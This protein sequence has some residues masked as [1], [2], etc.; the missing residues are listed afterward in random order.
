MNS[1]TAQLP[2]SCMQPHVYAGADT[3][4][5][6]NPYYDGGRWGRRQ[7]LIKNTKL[8][9]TSLVHSLL[10][11][12]LGIMEKLQQIRERSR[13]WAKTTD[14]LS[15]SLSVSPSLSFSVCLSVHICLCVRP[16]V[17]PCV[18]QDY[19]NCLSAGVVREVGD[20]ASKAQTKELI[21]AAEA[22][23]KKAHN[24]HTMECT[25]PPPATPRAS[26]RVP[27]VGCFRRRR[28]RPHGVKC[29]IKIKEHSNNAA[30]CYRCKK[31]QAKGDKK[32][33]RERER[34]GAR[35]ARKRNEKRR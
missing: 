24:A 18:Y 28:S 9:P 33:A 16:S 20:E 15:V 21:A 1:L 14:K 25:R 8:D 34:E 10:P 30:F 5:H 7:C 2:P 12:A 27:L 35:A 19:N 22:A 29:G 17:C 23:K 13:D 6:M 32:S 11:C 3:F 4:T 26:P 31:A